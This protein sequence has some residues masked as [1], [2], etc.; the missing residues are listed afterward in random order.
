M[1]AKAGTRKPI[2]IGEVADRDRSKEGGTASPLEELLLRQAAKRASVN[3]LYQRLYVQRVRKK[4]PVD[5]TELLLLRSLL[6]ESFPQ[7][8]AKVEMAL[9]HLLGMSDRWKWARANGLLRVNLEQARGFRVR[10]QGLAV[11]LAT[12]GSAIDELS[13]YELGRIEGMVGAARLAAMQA[14][15]AD[16]QS[17]ISGLPQPREGQPRDA[18]RFVY[19]W[20]LLDE[21]QE[22]GVPKRR[23]GRILETMLLF[24]AFEVPGNYDYFLADVRTKRETAR[25]HGF[26]RELLYSSLE[27]TSSHSSSTSQHIACDEK[28]NLDGTNTQKA[29][30]GK[31]PWS[32]PHDP[33][34]TSGGPDLPQAKANY[35]RRSRRIP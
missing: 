17:R 23:E 4:I 10:A 16:I 25:T 13:P 24:C 19:A 28:E 27:A 22:L 7:D 35:P 9:G 8:P 32:K 11:K 26:F 6:R 18:G 14:T 21:L 15:V 1:R 29:G 2:G 31:R 12:L 5:A 3:S 20:A 33:V 30:D 34:A